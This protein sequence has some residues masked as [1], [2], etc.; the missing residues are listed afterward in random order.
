MT[1]SRVLTRYSTRARPTG[2]RCKG[3]PTCAAEST[4]PL[5]DQPSVN[6]VCKSRSGHSSTPTSVSDS[7]YRTLCNVGV[8]TSEGPVEPEALGL[9]VVEVVVPPG[10][11]GVGEPVV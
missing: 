9:A 10:V 1:A 5:T 7:K 8:A 4:P 11:D 3:T 6:D 2:P